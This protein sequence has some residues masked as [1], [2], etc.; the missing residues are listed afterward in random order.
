MRNPVV[1][2]S[3]AAAL[4]IAALAAPAVQAQDLRDPVIVCFTHHSQPSQH[5]IIHPFAADNHPQQIEP[6]RGNGR[7]DIHAVSPMG[8]LSHHDHN[9][10]RY[11]LD[12]RWVLDGNG[13]PTD[14]ALIS[15]P[16]SVASEANPSWLYDSANDSADRVLVD[17]SAFTF[18]VQ[19]YAGRVGWSLDG[20][21]VTF[22]ATSVATGLTG[23]YVGDTVDSNNDGQADGLANIFLAV[24]GGLYAS[25]GGQN[26]FSVIL[27]GTGIGVYDATLSPGPTNPI[28]PVT[29]LDV[30]TTPG[31]GPALTAHSALSRSGQYLAFCVQT[32]F[33]PPPNNAEIRTDLFVLDVNIG[34]ASTIQVTTTARA[35]NCNGLGGPSWSPDDTEIAYFGAQPPSGG[36]S[37]WPAVYRIAVAGTSNAKQLTR[38]TG[39]GIEDS[40][41]YPLWR[42]KL[43]VPAAPSSLAA[44]SV[45]SNQINLSWN[46]NASN[47]SGFE[48]ERSL[49]STTWSPLSTT[50]P[51]ATAYSDIGLSSSTTY[52][53]RARAINGAGASGYSNVSSAT[54]YGDAL[55]NAD[56]PVAGTVTG[57]YADTQSS[58][59]IR[60]SIREVLSGGSPSKKYSYLEHK[61]TIN[62]AAA[63]TVTFYVEAHH[64][65]NSEGDDFVFAWS[66]DNVNFTNMATVTK[67]ADDNAYQTFSLPATTNGT[68]YVR[69]RDANRTAGRQVLDTVYVDHI[70]VRSQ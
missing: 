41:K 11:I 34:F 53:Y 56:V 49:N 65:A 69:V 38:N 59:D 5:P 2:L 14:W 40:S 50:A 23:I 68:I 33:N 35:A 43:T 7:E 6:D 63:P 66:S 42:Q 45:T 10:Q 25:W 48:I 15:T 70:F 29:D 18:A 21:H 52:Y 16:S 67:T 17:S 9:G 47:E 32:E 55:A 20:A 54:T 13:D 36:G 46:D 31:G 62:V 57:T 8:D 61:W 24:E 19:H 1:S 4:G 27:P 30:G 28:F 3:L 64:T 58:N 44:T 12:V 22:V 39:G 60:E 51:N 37:I 26:R